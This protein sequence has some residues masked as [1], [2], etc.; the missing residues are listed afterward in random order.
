M[1]TRALGIGLAALFVGAMAHAQQKQVKL[2]LVRTIQAEG[3]VIH[4]A[5]FSPDGKWLATAGELG[6]LR[7]LEVAT[8]KVLWNEKPGDHWSGVVAFS[9]DGERVA[10][11]G[12]HLTIHDAATGKERLR[13]EGSGP[14]GF[15]WLAD[16]RG[17]AYARGGDLV[18]D[19]SGQ[20]VVRASFEYPIN[21]I[22]A[23]DVGDLW[24][25]D[26]V[27]R[28]WRVLDGDDP[29]VLQSDHRQGDRLVRSVRLCV[30]AGV[31]FDLASKGPL[32]RGSELFDVP[33]TP[34]AL[35]VAPDGRSFAVGGVESRSEGGT[36]GQAVVRWWRE[37][38]TAF[39]DVVVTGSVAALAFHP[40]GTRLFVSTYEGGQALYERGGEPTPVPSH[41]AE[42]KKVALTLDGTA[43]A[44]Q[45]TQWSVHALDGRPTRVLRGAARVRPGRRA[46]ELLVEHPGKVVVWD[47]SSGK[48]LRSLITR[49]FP[50]GASAIGPGDLLFVEGSLFDEAGTCVGHLPEDVHFFQSPCVAHASDGRWAIGG[51]WGNHGDVG[52]LL[53][54]GSQGK[55]PVMVDERPVYFVTFSPDGKHLYYVHSNGWSS[56]AHPDDGRLC[57]RDTGTTALLD[58]VDARIAQWV[59]LDD[60]RALV[61]SEGRL[62]LWDV[63]KRRPIQTLLTGIGA[64]QVT[65]DR[66]TLVIQDRGPRGLATE[67]RV[68]RLE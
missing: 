65:D 3:G 10:C 13:V 28:V 63:D 1:V 41:P 68:Y 31:L 42:V 43:V 50:Y 45:G 38:G 27:G 12:R 35:A 22:A 6:D 5:S 46:A 18:V 2:E 14:K 20:A 49:R 44:V 66:R 60:S 34:F 58:E 64:F 19:K 40:D 30:V 24:V 54:T 47:A 37:G 4:A 36:R 67:V 51:V 17:F 25:G 52:C 32:R 21:T 57:I 61:R 16:G 7:M 53:L 8:G 56:S 62:Q 59:F 26:N 23:G 55:E 39:D 9:P 11:G 48:E 15:A 33:A 29:P